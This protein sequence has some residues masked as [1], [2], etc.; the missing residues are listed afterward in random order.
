MTFELNGTVFSHEPEPGQCLRTFVRD[1]GCFGVKKGCDQGDCGACTVWL[2]GA[3]VHSC[4]TPAKRV[5]GCAVTTIEGLGTPENMH[6]MQRNFVNAPGFQCG[7][8]TA[9][10]IMTAASLDDPMLD[11]LPRSM[12]GNLCRCTGYRAIEDAI[13]GVVG[14][15]ESAPGEA[16]GSSV[17]APGGVGVVTGTVEYT[18]DT[19]IEGLL[20]LKL[21]RSPHAHARIRSVDTAAALAVPGVER[22][23]TW[24]DV[25]NKLYTT[26]IHESNLVDPDDTLILDQVARYVGQRVVAVLATTLAAAEEGCRRVEIDWEVMPAVF[27]PEQAML[28]EAPTLHPRERDAFIHRAD[29]NIL[30]ELH[31]HIGN[32][33]QGFAD[34]DVIHEATYTTPRV[35]HA[36]LETHGS[37]TWIDEQ[38]QL[39]VRTSSQSPS[40]AKVKLSYLF[41]LQPNQIRVFCER[42][43]G[44]FGGKQEV[45]TEDLCVLA[46][47]DTGQPVSLEL[48]RAEE[49]QSVVG[50]PMKVSVKIGARLDGEFT[51]LQVTTISNTGAYGNHGGETLLAGSAAMQ[52][53][54][55]ANKKADLL[56]VYTNT[57]PSGGVRGYGMTQPSFAV[58]SA[59]DELAQAMGWDPLEIRRVNHVLPGDPLLAI[60]AGA[61]DVTFSENTMGQCIDAVLAAIGSGDGLPVP[62]GDEWLSGQGFATTLH[63]TAPPTEHRSEAK[64][65]LTPEGTYELHVGTVEFG[66]GTSTAHVQMVADQLGTLPSHI[67]LIQA[68]TARTGFD[69]GA[70]GSAGLFVS[71]KATLGAA[72]ALRERLLRLAAAE[73][74]VS[75]NDCQ[76]DNDVVIAGDQR[77]PL[78]QLFEIGREKGLVLADIHKAYGSPRSATF[79]AQGFRVAVNKVTGDVVIL[80]SVHAADCGVVINPQQVRG[81]IEG[82]VA[83]GIS[84]ALTEYLQFDDD[85]TVLN[86][87]LR[88]YRMLAYPDAPRTQVI[89]IESRDSA[90]PLYSKGIAES[91]INPVAPALVNAIADATG[92]RFRDLPVSPQRIFEPIAR[93]HAVT[94]ESWHADGSMVR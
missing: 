59:I 84:F 48:T 53:Y 35:Q 58:E 89:C 65:S 1:L 72:K 73:A 86:P 74:D 60:D 45:L 54:R 7:F 50:H 81:Q 19:K 52:L 21:V 47:L 25:P 70:F 4:I 68:D 2:D 94:V 36:H 20:H 39:N 75:P 17:G 32:I 87:D 64:V 46:T 11:D 88:M 62:A 26:A 30:I 8:C 42:V 61:S 33:E 67:R 13:K 90:G 31:S 91:C 6:P 18:M 51:A 24:K 10:M 85:H 12:K 40:L 55:V 80:Q 14:I 27:E 57:V 77:I 78:G 83:Q 3:P 15:A 38:G 23:Y 49:F 34:A 29:R 43:G 37:I 9:G 71:G 5:E 28:P 69:T 16:V 56:A 82:G 92:I 66:E 93:S 41:S 76:L 79:N 63:E 44:G 22:V